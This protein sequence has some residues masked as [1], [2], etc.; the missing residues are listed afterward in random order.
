[1]VEDGTAGVPDP[2]VEYQYYMEKLRI[3]RSAEDPS[4]MSSLLQIR[5]HGDRYKSEDAYKAWLHSKNG[6]PEKYMS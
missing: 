6:G 3:L 1:M 4:K 5:G 2:A